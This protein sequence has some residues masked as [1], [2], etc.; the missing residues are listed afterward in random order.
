MWAAIERT[1]AGLSADARKRVE[2]E[3]DPFGESVNF[4][5]FSANEE[6]KHFGA[7]VGLIEDEDRFGRFYG[8]E[9]DSHVPC[10]DGY[11]RMLGRFDIIRSNTPS[12]DLSVADLIAL[13]KEQVH[14][15]YRER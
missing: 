12:G 9:L 2:I 8:R 10:L 13:L 7:A 15:H 11:K 14:P 6:F 3:A 4:E 5:D 1:H